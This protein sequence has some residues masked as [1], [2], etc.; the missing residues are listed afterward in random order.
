LLVLF[1]D[2]LICPEISFFSGFLI[3]EKGKDEGELGSKDSNLDFMIQSQNAS[4]L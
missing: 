3:R 1:P 2:V 4:Q